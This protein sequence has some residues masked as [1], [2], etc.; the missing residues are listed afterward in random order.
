MNYTALAIVAAILYYFI[1][2]FGKLVYDMFIDKTKDL[3]L[4]VN[5]TGTIWFIGLIF[6]NITIL[7]FII[8]FYYYKTNYS[9]GPLGPKGDTGQP[10]FEGIQEEKCDYTP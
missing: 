10:G 4:N 2:V 1:S 9:I 8:S 6:I 5:K 3:K 7:I